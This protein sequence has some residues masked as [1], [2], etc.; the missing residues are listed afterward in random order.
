MLAN[1]LYKFAPNFIQLVC[2][3]REARLGGKVKVVYCRS[4]QGAGEFINDGTDKLAK[5]PFHMN[6]TRESLNLR[7]F[8]RIALRPQYQA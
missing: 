2:P 1:P 3:D 5:F 8:D 7:V 6:L 4:W